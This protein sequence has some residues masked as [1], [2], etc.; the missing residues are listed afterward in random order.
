M[1][2][3]VTAKAMHGYTYHVINVVMWPVQTMAYSNGS[4]VAI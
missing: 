2:N 3:C 1:G 4:A